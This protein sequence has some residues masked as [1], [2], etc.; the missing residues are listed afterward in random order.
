[1]KVYLD[2][3]GCKL[4]QSE[5][6]SLAHRFE[7][8][9]HRVVS[10]PEEADLCVLNT[11]A[12]THVA[13]RKSRQALRR[14]YR[15][16]PAARIA[17]LGCYAELEPD[18]L[19]HLPGVEWIVGNQDKERLLEVVGLPQSS[20]P[21]CPSRGDLSPMPQSR[22]RALVKIQDGCD[23]ACTYCVVHLAR[24]PQRSRPPHQVLAEI[25]SALAAGHREIVLTGVHIGA[26]GR[27]RHM[28]GDSASRPQPD[29][30]GLV[31]RILN[32]TDLHRLRL[33][34]IEPWDLAPGP[35]F[36]LWADP[37]LCPHLHLPLQAGADR[38]LRRMGRRYSA[39]EYARLVESA[40]AAIP[41]LALTT[42]IIAGFPGETEA[43]FRDSLRFVQAME[44]ARAHVFPYS[45]RAGTPAAAML[46]QVPGAARA[47]RAAAMRS[48]AEGSASAFRQR[49]VGRCME[50]LWERQREDTG[51]WDG[52]TGNYLRV[53]THSE[54]DLHNTL[55]TVRLDC[56]TPDGLQGTLVTM[57][58]Q[59]DAR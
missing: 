57:G 38:T 46:D 43:D 4:N 6:G 28:A 3:L 26:Y 27:D 51:H 21:A 15:A 41:D 20:Q 44:F 5:I 37:R 25:R 34:S 13:A 50:V 31:A 19:R 1:M 39:S 54:V 7:L 42:D 55:A 53:H 29:L 11:C 18:A 32:E 12:V 9:G 49:F 59:R 52:L 22:T 36:A 17:A 2:T 30:W 23:N 58:H 40:R 16:N 48:V 10:A 47:E 45:P 35:V 56:L 33:S 14:I 8:A 24:G